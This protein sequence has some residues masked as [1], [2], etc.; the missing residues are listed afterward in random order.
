MLNN[1]SWQGY[2]V[3]LALLTAGYYLVVYLL[4]FRKDFKISLPGKA[5]LP[6]SPSASPAVTS[7]LKEQAQPS[8]FRDGETEDE[9]S[10]PT[11]PT[12]QAVYACMDELTAYFESA[13]KAKVMKT[14]VLFAVQRILQKYPSLQTSEYKVSITKVIQT[15]AEH[16]C[17][18]HLNE[19][20]MRKVWMIR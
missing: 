3:T 8:L 1:I 18:V 17:S 12:E 5:G 14:E 11:D 2:W 15:E 16:H 7:F 9:F 19:E 20:E 6:K 10:T 4:Y 13:K